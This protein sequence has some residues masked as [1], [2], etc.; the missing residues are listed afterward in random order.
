MTTKTI[1]LENQFA[2]DIWL[3]ALRN[4]PGWNTFSNFGDSHL[5][6]KRYWPILAKAEKLDVPIYPYE[7][8][9][10]CMDFLA[11]LPLSEEERGSLY[12][13]NAGSLKLA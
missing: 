6:E 5:D 1:D 12:E 4:N 11:G 13:G 2:T 7:D 8:M 10:E 3:E 9:N